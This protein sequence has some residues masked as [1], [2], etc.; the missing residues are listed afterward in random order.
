MND[1]LRVVFANVAGGRLVGPDREYIDEDRT[2]YFGE[3]LA[4]LQPDVLIVTELKCDG[5]QL[6]RLAD[7]AMPGRPTYPIKHD[8]SDS[9]IPGVRQAPV[10]PGGP[11]SARRGLGR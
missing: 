2:T 6:D 3:A 8:F 5:D 11:G 4:R 7:L 1:E 10:R 9:H